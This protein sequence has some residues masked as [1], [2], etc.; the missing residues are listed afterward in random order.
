M[1]IR[2][3]DDAIRRIRVVVKE[4]DEAGLDYRREDQ[5]RYGVIDP[6]IRALGWDISDPKECHP[7]YPRPY[8]D[9]RVD[10]ALFRI[11]DVE[12]T[13]NNSI[14]PDI[15]ME[16]K[17]FRTLLDDE[18]V[19]QLKSYVQAEPRMR[20]DVAVLSRATLFNTIWRMGNT[21]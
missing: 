9:G 5:T 6:V 13:G 16:S 19:S 3:V 15:V 4:W 2:A 21:V 11:P 14:D 8:R 17:A 7:E 10:Y 1:S 12:A 20:R 18:A